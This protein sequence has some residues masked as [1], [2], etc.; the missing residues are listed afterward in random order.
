MISV[1]V[2]AGRSTRSKSD[3]PTPVNMSAMEAFRR[4][5]LRLRGDKRELVLI[6]FEQLIKVRLYK[7]SDALSRALK[8]M[9]VALDSWAKARTTQDLADM[10]AIFE[11]ISKVRPLR[12]EGAYR[13]HVV[14]RNQELGDRKA[15]ISR[16]QFLEAVQRHQGKSMSDAEIATAIAIEFQYPDPHTAGR[17]A[18]ERRI[19]RYRAKRDLPK[20]RDRKGSRQKAR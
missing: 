10:E 3:F 1:V 12:Q 20:R 8:D 2:A 15:K 17:E 11:L 16:S 5:L 13:R 9:L 6:V 7:N 18:V 19:R 14:Q 4:S